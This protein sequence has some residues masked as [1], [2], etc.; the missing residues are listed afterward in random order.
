MSPLQYNACLKSKSHPKCS[1]LTS[2]RLRER[3]LLCFIPF[4]SSFL[5]P[6]GIVDSGLARL[7]FRCC[8]QQLTVPGFSINPR[9]TVLL[10]N[11]NRGNNTRIAIRNSTVSSHHHACSVCVGLAMYRSMYCASVCVWY[12]SP[13]WVWW[14]LPLLSWCCCSIPLCVVVSSLK[15]SSAKHRDRSTAT[16]V[17]I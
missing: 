2:P 1:L 4:D 16:E 5:R 3:Q 7:P 13:W 10:V 12:V 8:A 9:C 6:C 11:N 17:S 15:S 14:L